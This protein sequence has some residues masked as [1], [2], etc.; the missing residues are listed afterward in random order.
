MRLAVIEVLPPHV[1]HAVAIEAEAQLA[2]IH[3]Q[4]RHVVCLHG[5]VVPAVVHGKAS[6][7]ESKLLAFRSA[8]DG[9][10]I[11]AVG[12]RQ[13][14]CR[15]SDKGCRIAFCRDGARV[16]AI[17]DVEGSEQTSVAHECSSS[18]ARGSHRSVVCDARDVHGAIA[19]ITAK[20]THIVT[21]LRTARLVED[22][23]GKRAGTRIAD[24][25]HGIR[26]AEVQVANGVPASIDASRKGYR[27]GAN[28]AEVVVKV[29]HINVGHKHSLCILL[30]LTVHQIAESAEIHAGCYLIDA[31]HLS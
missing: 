21:S 17:G 5:S 9:A 16:E 22:D 14:S 3:L 27:H 29:R 20:H 25:S 18:V 13:P 6:R 26:A 15:G 23:V 28:R 1:A 12:N 4:G 10:D 19:G 8:V 30:F 11:V 7:C 2:V 31:V 24:K